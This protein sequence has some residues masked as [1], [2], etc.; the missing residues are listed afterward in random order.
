M[1]F[2]KL[3]PLATWISS[4]WNRDRFQSYLFRKPAIPSPTGQSGHWLLPDED[5]TAVLTHLRTH[6]GSPPHTPVLDIPDEYLLGPKDHFFVVHDSNGIA[7]TIRYHYVGEFVSANC[8]PIYVVDCFCIHPTWRGKGVA[9]YL[10]TELHRYANRKKIPYAMFLKEGPKLAIAPAP[11]YTGVYAYRELEVSNPSPYVSDLTMGQAHRLMEVY[12]M[13]HSD[14]F[15]ILNKEGTNQ[16]WKMFRKG[17]HRILVC[18]QD[19]FQKKEGK[20]M[21]WMTAWLESATMTKSVREE[22]VIALADSLYPHFEYVWINRQWGGEKW[23][24][25]GGFHWYVYQWNSSITM[26]M[27]YSLP[28]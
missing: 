8:E 25:D 12:R 2:W 11:F 4:F 16:M 21:A 9:D 26:T 5:R 14:R 10:L 19:A 24:A 23:I 7:G 22:A 3:Y 15:L 1:V 28:M 18:M 17:V 27:S 6:F 13:I 20:R